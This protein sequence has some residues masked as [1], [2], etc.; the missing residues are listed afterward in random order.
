MIQSAKIAPPYSQI[1]IL[2]PGARV[3]VPDWKKDFRII[4]TETCIVV[5]CLAE[6][7]GE[8]EFLLGDMRQVDPGSRAAFYGR[9]KTP[10]R[11]I[12]L[13][14]VEGDVVLKAPTSQDETTVR[15]WTNKLEG[16]DRVVVGIE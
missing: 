4:S 7:D 3:M 15:I 5:A 10:G 6:V 14:T 1:V 12:S 16:P 13:E 8:T 11:H 9:L 2:D